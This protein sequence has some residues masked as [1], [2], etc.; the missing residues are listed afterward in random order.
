MSIP[1]RILR[2][3]NEQFVRT[4]YF[5]L[6]WKSGWWMVWTTQTSFPNSAEWQNQPGR[7]GSL[8]LPNTVSV[9]GR[10]WLCFKDGTEAKEE[11]IL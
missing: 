8:P 11:P 10:S 6:V 2:K 7:L 4:N 1:G 3:I 9:V 5:S